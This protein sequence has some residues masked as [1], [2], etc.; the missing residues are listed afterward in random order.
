MTIF[1][2]SHVDLFFTH[3][4]FLQWKMNPTDEFYFQ[5]YLGPGESFIVLTE[6]EAVSRMR[7]PVLWTGSI[8]CKYIQQSIIN[9]NKNKYSF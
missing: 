1:E 8:R 2:G 6:E 7:M 5:S 3:N 9:F 4:P